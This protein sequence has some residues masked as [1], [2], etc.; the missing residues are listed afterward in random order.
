MLTP[1]EQHE[2]QRLLHEH[3]PIRA[4]ARRLNRDVK[5]IRRALGRSRAPSPSAPPKLAPYHELIKEHAQ[6]RLRSPRILREIRARGYTGST[7]ILKDFLRT[8]GP[9]P[10]RPPRTFHRFETR[11]GEEAQSDWSPYRV[12]I[13]NRETIVHA[14]S[15]VLCF[16]RRLFVAFFRD[17]RLP[18]LLWAHHEAFRYHGGL[19]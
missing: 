4:I 13:A 6:Q 9:H 14:F 10:P 7:T 8:L 18:T 12:P 16:C 17:E 19:C 5:T 1:E 2:L 11:P 3:I 15:L